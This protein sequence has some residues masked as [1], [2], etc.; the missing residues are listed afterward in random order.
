MVSTVSQLF[1][2]AFKVDALWQHKCEEDKAL[3]WKSVDV[4]WRDLYTLDLSDLCPHL[5]RLDRYQ[6]P[7][8][9]LKV[10]EYLARRQTITCHGTRCPFTINNLWCAL[11]LMYLSDARSWRSFQDVRGAWLWLCWLWSSRQ[12]AHDEPH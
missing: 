12:C 1:S 2:R 11:V 6:L 4:T 8:V 7:W 9:L 5:N 3:T 10:D